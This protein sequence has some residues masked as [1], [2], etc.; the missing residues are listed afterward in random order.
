MEIRVGVHTAGLPVLEKLDGGRTLLRNQLI[1]TAFHW[2]KTIESVLPGRIEV[3]SAPDR[4]GLTLINVLPLETYLATVIS[5]EMN[6]EAPMEFLKTHAVLS[7]SWVV[8]KILRCHEEGGS[9]KTDDNGRHIGW[10]DTSSHTGFHVCADDHCQRYQGVRTIPFRALK[11]ISLTAGEQILDTGGKPVDA[12]FSKCCGGRTELFSTCWQDSEPPCIESVGDPW[13]DLSGLESDKKN[14]LLATVLKDY[15]A[16]TTDFLNWKET[17]DKQF[18]AQRLKECF[19]LNIGRKA[20][21]ITPLSTGT[22]GRHSL[23]KIKGDDGE[24]VIGKELHIRR[25]LSESHLKSSAFSVEDLGDAFLLHGRGW[26]HGVGLCQIGAAHMSV[27]HTYSEILRHYFP[28]A[29]IGK[30]T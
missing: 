29:I 2:R 27:T 1:G 24:A 7:R 21:S 13:C 17:V 28:K 8:G 18:I 11:A 20:I 10:D 16:E 22:S 4:D 26:G 19:G 5:S 12:R 9:G 6:A 14:E 15:D 25:V 23:I 30:N 3:L